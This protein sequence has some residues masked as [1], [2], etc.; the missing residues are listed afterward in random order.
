MKVVIYD[1]SSK[2]LD[3]NKK[4]ESHNHPLRNTNNKQ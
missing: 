1:K 3:G 2:K 4:H